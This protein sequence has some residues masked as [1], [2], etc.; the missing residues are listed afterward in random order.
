[1][2]C[3]TERNL[4]SAQSTIAVILGV[5]SLAVGRRSDERGAP[6]LAHS[7]AY[8]SEFAE[9]TKQAA[10]KVSDRLGP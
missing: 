9:K 4:H 8:Q 6:E 2:A 1:M 5:L 10:S 7:S 3:G